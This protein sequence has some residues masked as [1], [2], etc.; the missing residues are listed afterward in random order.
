[1]LGHE[2]LF[3]TAHLHVLRPGARLRNK[4]HPTTV[5]KLLWDFAYVCQRL[6]TGEK[7]FI[8]KQLLFWLFICCGPLRM[9]RFTICNMS[10]SIS[11]IHVFVSDL[12]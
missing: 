7:T 11:C 6:K 12:Y 8:L 3:L 2:A 5:M 4:V 10:G 9:L 1:M